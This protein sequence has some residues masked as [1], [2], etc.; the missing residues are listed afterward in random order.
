MYKE[1]KDL[2]KLDKKQ[3]EREINNIKILLEDIKKQKMLEIRPKPLAEIDTEKLIKI[4]EEFISESEE[5]GIDE[6]DNI[7]LWFERVLELVYG[8]YVIDWIYKNYQR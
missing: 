3:L 4:C 1:L 7:G 5:F 8:D 2:K 6:D